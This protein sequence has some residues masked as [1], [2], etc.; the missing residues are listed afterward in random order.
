ME[1]LSKTHVYSITKKAN[2]PYT[3][4]LCMLYELK[5]Q[6]QSEAFFYNQLAIPHLPMEVIELLWPRDT[7]RKVVKLFWEV[8]ERVEEMET[9]D[10]AS[11]DKEMCIWQYAY[12]RNITW[13]DFMGCWLYRTLSA[14]VN[15]D[16]IEFEEKGNL[17]K[18]LFEIAIVKESN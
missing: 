6:K 9:S 13:F 12:P 11:Y 4:V 1:T 16:A 18:K 5:C 2:V 15:D 7:V 3:Y 17:K 10:T 8:Y 14:W